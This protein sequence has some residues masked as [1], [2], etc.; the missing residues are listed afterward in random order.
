[1]CEIGSDEGMYRIYEKGR[2]MTRMT[3][4]LELL[5]VIETNTDMRKNGFTPHAL[6][7]ENV[8][9]VPIAAFFIRLVF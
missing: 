7:G 5:L 3:W 8:P 4:H 2:Q 9:P 6:L 1:M